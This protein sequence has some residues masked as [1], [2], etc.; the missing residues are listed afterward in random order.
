MLALCYYQIMINLVVLSSKIMVTFVLLSGHCQPCAVS[1][2][3][4][5]WAAV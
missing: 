3:G 2:Y 5:Q 4:R 1:E